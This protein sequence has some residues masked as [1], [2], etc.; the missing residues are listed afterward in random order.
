MGGR[1]IPSADIQK[2]TFFFEKPS[3]G[4]SIPPV[5]PAF[6][7][8]TEVLLGIRSAG[9]GKIPVLLFLLLPARFVGPKEGK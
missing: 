2:C 1:S 5:W 6:W 9:S 8:T 7:T 3:V 4:P